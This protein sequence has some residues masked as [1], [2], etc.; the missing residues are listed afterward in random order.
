MRAE[1]IPVVDLFAGPGGLG[2][3]FTA[4]RSRGGHPLFRIV[5][6]IEMDEAAHQTLELRSFF[7]QFTKNDVPDEYYEHLQ[8]KV[9]R[10]DLFSGHPDQAAAARSE[11]W[12]AELGKISPDVVD[13]K[14]HAGL[15]G[16]KKWVL[17][18]GPPCQAYSVIGRS[19]N[20]GIHPAD[21]RLFLYREYLRILARHRPSAFIFENVKGLL[22]SKLGGNGIFHQIITD[23]SDPYSAMGCGSP[24]RYRLYSLVVPS[25]SETL[26]GNPTFDFCDFIIKCEDYGIPQS[27]HRVI[28]LGIRED[29]APTRYHSSFRANLCRLPACSTGCPA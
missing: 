20:R 10:D 7:R 6:S 13:K 2:E 8:G 19:R 3:G 28:L 14:I 18:G 1:P 11:A 4:T 17:C 29:C 23:L 12:K 26:D 16:A 27:R 15:R 5:L 21:H 24:G 22:S 25:R 9:S